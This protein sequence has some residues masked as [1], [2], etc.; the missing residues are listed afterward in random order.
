[1][2]EA[3]MQGVT[4]TSGAV[5]GSASCSR[6]LRHAAQLS[7]GLGFEPATFRSLADLLYPLSYSRPFN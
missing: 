6:T 1:M 5:W 3:A 2:A 7:P 4:R